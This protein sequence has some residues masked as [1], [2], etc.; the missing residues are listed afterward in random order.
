MDSIKLLLLLLLLDGVVMGDKTA[1]EEIMGDIGSTIRG[2]LICL[3]AL[4]RLVMI[5]PLREVFRCKCNLSMDGSATA[6]A[7]VVVKGGEVL[8]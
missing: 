8:P 6:V 1:R 4:P 5:A 2:G 7:A 3:T